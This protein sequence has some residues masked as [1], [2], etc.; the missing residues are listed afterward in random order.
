MLDHSNLEDYNDP[1]MYDAETHHFEPYGPFYLKLARRYAGPV[2]ELGCG[3]GRYT[4]PLAQA[5]IDITGLDIVPGMLERARQKAVGLSITWVEADMRTFQLD[6]QFR[7]IMP[8]GSAFHHLVTRPD[9]EAAL[10]Q[11]HQ[12]LDSDGIFVID[13]RIPRPN[14]MVNVAEE[15]EWHRYTDELGR[16]IRLSGTDRYDPI[17]QIKHEDAYRRWTDAQGQEIT[18][19]ARYATRY[20]FPQEME[21]LLHYNGFVIEDCYGNT[22]FGPV[23]EESETMHYVCRRRL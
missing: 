8:T 4:I 15:Q 23:T 20:I 22:N 1:I 21:A 10:A 14:E 2:L 9:Q 19:R 3:T 17:N 7:M 13:N 18:Q 16:A 11:I 5:G 12:H 6:R